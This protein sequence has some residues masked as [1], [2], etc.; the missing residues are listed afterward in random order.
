MKAEIVIKSCFQKGFRLENIRF[1][2][3]KIRRNKQV[4]TMTISKQ[5]KS[6]KV[7]VCRKVLFNKQLNDRKCADTSY[8]VAQ[9]NT[10]HRSAQRG[11][12]HHNGRFIYLLHLS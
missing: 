6:F 2:R 4:F 3:I 1:S 12:F 10:D 11:T 5:T 8:N 9:Y 7:D